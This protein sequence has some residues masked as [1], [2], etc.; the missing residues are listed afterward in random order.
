MRTWFDHGAVLVEHLGEPHQP[1]QVVRDLPAHDGGADPGKAFDEPLLPQEVQGVPDRVAAGPELAAEVALVGQHPLAEPV[2]EQL[3][4]DE[5]GDLPGTV[6][7]GAAPQREGAGCVVPAG[8]HDS[9]DR[10]KVD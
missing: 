7:A 1:V 8:V 3:A 5:V 6:G 4:P 9:H 2:I 10:G